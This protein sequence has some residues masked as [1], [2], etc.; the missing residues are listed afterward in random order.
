MWIRSEESSINHVG[1][2]ILGQE[3]FIDL[4]ECLCQKVTLRLKAERILIDT[5]QFIQHQL[6]DPVL[7]Q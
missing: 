5:L 7:S 3:I 4:V 6:E 1:D 2:K